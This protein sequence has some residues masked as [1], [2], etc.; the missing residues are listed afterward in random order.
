MGLFKRKKREEERVVED[1]ELPPP[2]KTV[3]VVPN[4]R[5]I[6]EAVVYMPN[7]EYEVPA[8]LAA[9]FAGNGW[10][11]GTTPSLADADLSIDRSTIG[12]KGGE[13]G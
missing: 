7:N 3:V 5:F 4:Q 6:H 8:I 10:L 11:L 12:H 13:L 2:P 1:V 9:Y